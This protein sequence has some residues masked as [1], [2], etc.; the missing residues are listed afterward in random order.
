MKFAEEL[1]P[2]GTFKGQQT[3][4]AYIDGTLAANL[5]V[6]AE[7]IVDDMHFC[8][9]ITGNDSV[10][11]GK[12]TIKTQIASYL[13]WK[14][15]ELHKS[16]NTFTHNNV[17]MDASQLPERSLSLPQFSVVSLDE[18]DKLTDNAM[19]ETTHEL[20]RYFRKCRQ[21]NQ[22]LILILPSFFEL[23]K[24]YAL[25][26]SHCL[27]NVKFLNKFERGYFSFFGPKSKKSLYLKGKRDWDYDI[28][29]PDFSGRFFGSY[30]FFPNCAEETELYKQMKYQDMVDDSK[31]QKTKTPAQIGKEVAIQLFRQ[32][33]N[34]MDNLTLKELAK[35][36]GVSERTG[37]RWLSSQYDNI[38]NHVQPPPAT[39]HHIM[40]NPMD[41][42]DKMIETEQ[43]EKD[44]NIIKE[45]TKDENS[46]D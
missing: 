3:A 30:V 12:T 46:M 31:S 8:I 18:G 11:N 9:L 25:A 7:K 36:F 43:T 6:Y 16:K 35:G 37:S 45:Q 1:F 41:L 26:R 4:G 32:L 33:Y 21:L 13:T 24:F 28:V 17:C 22:I 23:P 2:L 20:K 39:R 5:D 19:K 14:I 34:N 42:E 44:S 27:I 10:G 29:K 38:E 40:I 15:N